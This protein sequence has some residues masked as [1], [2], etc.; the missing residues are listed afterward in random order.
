MPPLL[1][2]LYGPLSSRKYDLGNELPTALKNF[3]DNQTDLLSLVKGLKQLQNLQFLM[4]VVPHL[5][6]PNQFAAR[7]LQTVFKV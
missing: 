6:D 7:I 2:I 4:P 1:V 5:G 3:S